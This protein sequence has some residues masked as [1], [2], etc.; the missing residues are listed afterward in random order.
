M[1]DTNLYNSEEE[2][3][4]PG[5]EKKNPFSVPEDYFSASANRLEHKYELSALPQLSAIKKQTKEETRAHYF[6]AFEAKMAKRLEQTDELNPFE[7]LNSIAKKNNF[8]VAAG[9]FDTV[10]DNVKEKYHAANRSRISFLGQIRQLVFRPG[11]AVSFALVLVAGIAALWNADSDRVVPGDC[12]TLACLERNELLN[13]QTVRDF[14][15]EN[16]YEM[17]DVE[18]LDEQISGIDS[19]RQNND[20]I[21]T[22]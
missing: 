3:F 11:V 19:T 22:E 5:M 15:D 16:L 21:K 6:A 12:K 1:Q 13:E 17:V 7:R 18:A 20:S 8:A 4:L 2:N 10:A 14:D 9:Y